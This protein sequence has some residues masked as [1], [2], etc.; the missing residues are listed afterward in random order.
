[1]AAPPATPL[2]FA[3]IRAGN[4]LVDLIKEDPMSG[5][6]TTN[7]RKIR[8][9]LVLLTFALLLVPAAPAFAQ[10]QQ[11]TEDPPA[12]QGPSGTG[13]NT[14]NDGRTGGGTESPR[15]GNNSGASSKVL[16]AIAVGFVIVVIAVA[17]S[18]RGRHKAAEEVLADH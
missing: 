2:S 4:N 12:S 11:G 3:P 1:M 10:A 9:L 15:M 8:S 6:Q 18:T 7:G 16:G 14:P 17:A 5:M 13:G